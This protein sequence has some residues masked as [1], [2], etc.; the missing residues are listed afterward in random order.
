MTEKACKKCRVLVT[1]DVCA[2]CNGTEL[3]KSW[4]GQILVFNP[5]GS[6][7]AEAIGAKIPG[8]YAL[9]IKND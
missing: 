1:G 8:K 4:E 7:V 2:Q 3:T 5:T 6:Q 9:K